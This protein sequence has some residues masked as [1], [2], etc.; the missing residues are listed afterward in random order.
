MPHIDPDLTADMYEMAEDML[1]RCG[2]RHYEISNWAKPGFE[3]SHNL[4]YWH[5]LPYIGVGVAAHS[6]INGHRF[7][8]T[9]DLDI[10]LNAF[11]RNKQPICELDEIIGPELQLSETVILGLRLSEGIGTDTI[12]NH[13]GIDLFKRYESEIEELTDLG[14][15]ECTDCCIRLSP[16]GRLLG[17]EVFWRFLP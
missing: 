14:L 2:Y 8:N 10:Y 7:A 3:C 12:K 17:N 5:N 6:C 13:F 9:S 15:V 4:V 16:R 11:S 1:G